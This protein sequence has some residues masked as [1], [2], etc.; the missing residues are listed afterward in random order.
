[1]SVKVIGRIFLKTEKPSISTQI[2]A[3]VTGHALSTCLDNVTT[4]QRR[5]K[6]LNHLTI[7]ACLEHIN[8]DAKSAI[9]CGNQ[10]KSTNCDLRSSDCVH[11]S[12]F[13]S[14]PYKQW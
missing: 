4:G 1:M 2:T 10:D 14:Q 7:T 3:P 12:W 5:F 11:L 8:Q 9:L 6:S 13:K